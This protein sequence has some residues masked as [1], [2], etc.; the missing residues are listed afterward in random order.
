MLRR[1]RLMMVLLFVFAGTILIAVPRGS[2]FANDKKDSPLAKNNVTSPYPAAKSNISKSISNEDTQTATE[3][4]D[5]VKKPGES[6]ISISPASLF[7]TNSETAQTAYSSQT[8]RMIPQSSS[9]E[10]SGLESLEAKG[11]VKKSAE[12]NIASLGIRAGKKGGFDILELLGDGYELYADRVGDPLLPAKI[13]YISVPPGSKLENLNIKV[14]QKKTLEHP[15]NLLPKQP[16]SPTSHNIKKDPVAISSDLTASDQPFPESPVQFI[17]TATLRGH[18]MLVF[19][20]W[21]LQYIPATGSVIVNEHFEWQFSARPGHFPARKYI[22]P[23][24]V[25][26]KLLEH[27]VINP[28]QIETSSTLLSQTSE[29]P[30]SEDCDYLI[31]TNSALSSAF[32]TLAD[33]KEF[34]GLKAEVVT[35]EFIAANYSGNDI[36]E[37]I[38]NCVMDYATNRGTVW[39]LLGGDDTVVPDRNCYGWV[40]SSDG[41]IEDKTIPTDLYY[42]GLDDFD[43]NDDHD[44]KG[45][46]VFADGDTV[47]LYPDVFIGRAPVRSLSDASAFV[48]KTIAYTTNPPPDNFAE[49][50]LLCGVELWH[51]WRGK[52]DAH[53]RTEDMWADYMA[54]YWDGIR[55]RFYDT[56]TDFLG[57]ASYDVTDDNLQDQ[58]D[59]GYGLI[60]VASHGSQ[61][62]WGMEIGD[63]F[64]TTDAQGCVNAN[65]QGLI[66]TMACSTNAFEQEKYTVDPCLSESFLRN[67]DGGA[68][69]YIGSSRYG[70][71]NGAKST[72]PGT[73]IR[74]ARQFFHHLFD[75]SA[76]ESGNGDDPDPYRYAQRLG[77]VHAS[78][79][80][81]YA[82]NS[83]IKGSYR[84]IQFALNLMGDPYLKV[85]IENPEVFDPPVIDTINIDECISE[86]STSA[87]SVSASD[88]SGGNL[89]YAWE[90]LDGGDIIGSDENVE[91]DPPDTGPIVCPYRVN[92]TVM[93]DESGLQDSETIEIH[94]SLNGDNDY[95]SDVDGTD[96]F[97]MAG[98][99]FD[100]SELAAFADGFGRNDGCN[101]P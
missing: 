35:T 8:I 30:L 90:A 91:F 11:S 89:T 42:A 48:A 7:F 16:E 37:K 62:F 38:K 73:S 53:W 28:D 81:F 80:M 67:S 84:W 66:Y 19:R 75:N 101:C 32:Q 25:M 97:I 95:D 50:A 26:D 78:H 85:L 63:G 93:S 47:D 33:Q 10:F 54:P 87:I 88:P 92:V 13:V 17:E 39:V 61:T 24:P 34:M 72:T 49:T 36:Q 45:C 56:G 22:K 55:Y 20:I 82:P 40:D 46:E 59:D 5:A 98:G 96:L 44:D 70:W 57:G 100:S 65:R 94:V 3:N 12:C 60:F 2:A 86:L 58:I 74:Y 64:G 27:T 43:W 83:T 69:A 76:M 77:A 41:E 99:S 31:I 23:S 1:I 15:F 9:K 79:K 14:H 51:T 6:V 52:S 29:A 4:S 71:G 18:S 21:P 68:V